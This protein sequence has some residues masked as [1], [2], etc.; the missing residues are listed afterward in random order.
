MSYKTGDKFVI[1]I[2]EIGNGLYRAKPFKTLVF[3]EYGLDQLGQL[4]NGVDTFSYNKGM[5]EALE[6]VGKV[7]YMNADDRIEAFGDAYLMYIIEQGTR[8]VMDKY[9]AW[10]E[11]V[12][13]SK[14]AVD[15]PILVRDTE[16]D[17]WKERHFA[18]FEDGTVYSYPNGRTSWSGNGS[19]HSWKY[20]KLA[21]GS[22]E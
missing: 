19:V 2:E 3:D 11:K 9:K 15:T 6:M 18:K 1:E 13:W 10:K 7:H 17:K 14:V 8:K 22:E 20:A 21:E 12:D 5:E 16:N 4:V